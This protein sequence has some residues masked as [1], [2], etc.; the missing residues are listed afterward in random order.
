MEK[1]YISSN[2]YSLQ[3]RQTKKHGK[4][5]DLVFRVVTIDGEEKQKKVSG[6]QTKTLAKQYY[7]D[8]VTEHCEL[9]KNN[10]LKKKDTAKQ[11]PLVGDL[12]REYM[13]TLGNVNK[14][15]VIYD[16]DNLFR[17]YI[18]PDF[19]D[20]KLKNVTAERLYAWQDK[21]WSMKN[22]KTKKYFSQKYLTKI[23]GLFKTFLSW[24]EK[25]YG[26]KNPFDQMDKPKRQQKKA[27]MLFWTQD[28]F[29][30]FISVVDDEMYHAL[31]TFMFYTGRR[32]GELFA[33]SPEDVQK[34]KIAFTKSVT[35]RHFGKGTWEVTSTKEEKEAVLPI[36]KAVQDEIKVYQPPKGNFYFGGEK[37]LAQTTVT[38]VFERYIEKAN[39]KRIR[40]HDLRHSFVSL[41]IHQNASVW[42]IAHL[43]S[44][45][46]EM[47][48]STYGHFYLNDVKDVLNNIS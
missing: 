8:F 31:F 1:Y 27:E 22:K 47:V 42:T 44:D 24:V 26:Y 11:E 14:A 20:V 46:P 3:E 18:L 5:Y 15:S 25:R 12:I 33:L 17:N 45:T 2:K 16:K 32:K 19:E 37:P 35:R 30:Q 41:L 38:R 39:V 21:L 40:I 29:R 7:I 28:E 48:L 36:C 9:V 10:P 34:D 43:I 13:S 4:V 6:F 23:R